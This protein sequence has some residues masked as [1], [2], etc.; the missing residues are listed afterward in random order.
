MPRFLDIPPD[1]CH[2]CG[3]CIAVCPYGAL[4]T[5]PS[6]P[7]VSPAC[8][9]CGACYA[10][11][12]GREV[13]FLALNRFLYPGQIPDVYFGC[14]TKMFLG[15]A[16]KGRAPGSSSG[17]V[18]TAL[19]ANAMERKL[20][21]AA[22]VVCMDPSAPWLPRAEVASRVQEVQEASGSKY[23]LVPANSLLGKA[24]GLRGPTAFVGLPCHLH[25]V[26]KLQISQSPLTSPIAYSIGLFCGFNLLPDATLFLL[27]KLRMSPQEIKKIHYR[28][29]GWPG[30]F[31]AETVDGRIARVPKLAFNFLHWAYSPPRCVL[32]P[33]L[34]AELADISVGD[35]WP[36][37]KGGEAFSSIIVRNER[38][39]ELLDSAAAS[40]AVELT[41]LT[42][43]DLYRSHAHLINYKKRSFLV[44]RRT[45]RHT[46]SYVMKTPHLSPREH[47]TA[48]LSSAVLR[49]G[50]SGFSRRL[51]GIVPLDTLGRC[52]DLARR[53]SIKAGTRHS[54]RYWTLS[55]V[56]AHWD[57]TDAYDEFNEKTYSYMR[58]F[59]DAYKMIGG[60]IADH[61]RVLDISCRTGIGA[62]FF[63]SRR[64]LDIVGMASSSSQLRAARERLE[65]AGIPFTGYEWNEMRLPF[66][67]ESLDF[68][69]SF[70]TIEHT[71]QY[72]DLLAEIHRV[73]KKG[74]GFLL[75]TPNL[76][77]D[78]IHSIAD[79]LRLHHG[80]GPH[81]FIPRREI[82]HALKSS[83]FAIEQEA[84][85]VLI[86]YG[87]AWLTSL[88]ER[89]EGLLPDRIRRIVCLRRIF[90]CTRATKDNS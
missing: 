17:G 49:F 33:D 79:L 66:P 30:S 62:L 86:P 63:G 68:A 18:V 74:G 50:R 27:K 14:S 35:Y 2:N 19:L 47:V 53:I 75:T 57:Q 52:A 81:R 10:I 25:G 89:I 15:R 54:R 78:P 58:R 45:S 56:A 73:L 82:L 71:F 77:W 46:P 34:F 59:T 69:L 23:T 16:E 83:G 64:K 32:C 48:L 4:S 65:K 7:Q 39:Q 72:E 9:G 80:E 5:G 3:T 88:G 87:P 90:F 20:I 43:S 28:Y 70:E 12:P 1:R 8:K 36:A 38:G 60:R 51:M 61:A 84:S 29:G 13:D 44:R 22:H 6:R 31:V 24:R 11:C 85:T 26:R 21:R 37:E 40:G 41:D 55:D 67:D 76:L 42:A